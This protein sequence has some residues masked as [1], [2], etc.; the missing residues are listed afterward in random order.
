MQTVLGGIAGHVLGATGHNNCDVNHTAQSL[1]ESHT[2]FLKK[3]SPQHLAYYMHL[4]YRTCKLSPGTL[5]EQRT[6]QP[7]SG[8]RVSGIYFYYPLTSDIMCPGEETDKDHKTRSALPSNSM[9]STPAVP[10]REH[11]LTTVQYAQAIPPVLPDCICV[12]RSDQTTFL[13]E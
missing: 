13:G 6:D 8:G 1:C 2:T 12:Q 3:K 11:K 7:L 9:S 4:I 5:Q 10:Y